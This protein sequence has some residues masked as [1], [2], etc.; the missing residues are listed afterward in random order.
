MLARVPDKIANGSS[1][2][3]HRDRLAKKLRPIWSYAQSIQI[4]DARCQDNRQFLPVSRFDHVVAGAVLQADIQDADVEGIIFHRRKSAF[5]IENMLDKTKA[6][7]VQRI[8]SELPE[9][10]VILSHDRGYHGLATGPTAA[11]GLG[12][13][14]VDFPPTVPG[15]EH[16]PSPK[17]S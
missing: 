6:N 16:F 1:P 7:D 4:V 13:Y 17:R 8:G 10:D 14:H 5:C 3:I 15:F 2:L 11:T 9:R 12:Q